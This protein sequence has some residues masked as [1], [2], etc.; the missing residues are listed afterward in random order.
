[1]ILAGQETV[2]KN[3]FVVDAEGPNAYNERISSGLHQIRLYLNGELKT[4]SIDDFVPTAV[5][6]GLP[7]PLCSMTATDGEIWL[8]LIEKAC[9]K[10]FLGYERLAELHALDIIRVFT[11]APQVFINHDKQQPEEVW[12]IIYSQS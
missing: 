1:M 10:V 3:A 8:A 5:L 7:N 6:G 9:A 2:F 12:G 11:P 4:V